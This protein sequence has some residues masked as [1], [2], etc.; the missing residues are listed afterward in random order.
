MRCEKCGRPMKNAELWQ[1]GG[2]PQAPTSRSMQQVCWDCRQKPDQ[3]SKAVE[4]SSILSEA[5]EV[6]RRFETNQI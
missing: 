2:N 4:A 3:P 6:V 5:N 1:L